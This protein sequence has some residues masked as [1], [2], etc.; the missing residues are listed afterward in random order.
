M[1]AIRRCGSVRLWKESNGNGYDNCHHLNYSSLE[2]EGLS[3]EVEQGNLLVFLGGSKDFNAKAYLVLR[4]AKCAKDSQAIDGLLDR[5]VCV[6][7][8]H[9]GANPPG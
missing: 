7:A 6:L 4:L 2:G 1:S 3:I 5:D 9:L 8:A